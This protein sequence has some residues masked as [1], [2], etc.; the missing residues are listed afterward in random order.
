MKTDVKI[1]KVNFLDLT[2]Q[3]EKEYEFDVKLR[4]TNNPDKA[5]VVFHS[6]NTADVKLLKP[7]RNVSLGQLCGMYDNTRV[8]ASGFIIG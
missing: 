5:V 2:L 1:N 4:S 7:S 3:F 8:V 6:D